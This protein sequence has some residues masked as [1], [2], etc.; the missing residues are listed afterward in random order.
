MS[1]LEDELG[2]VM[3]EH[4]DEA[5]KAAELL[6][7][8]PEAPRRRRGSWYVVAAA[9]VL[10]VGVLA[11]VWAARDRAHGPTGSRPTAPVRTLSCPA[12]YAGAAPWVP[13]KPT[14]IDAKSRL[15]PLKSPASALICAYK[16]LNG[17]DKQR[18]WAL[19]GRRLLAGELDRL[20]AEL[21]WQPRSV[22]DRRHA[23]TLMAG[24]QVNYLI[25]LAYP[26]GGTIWVSATDEPNLCVGGANGEFTA[27]TGFAGRDV[28]K[29]YSTGVWP[30]RQPANCRL[31]GGGRLGQDTTMV[32]AGVTSLTICTNSGRV[33]K[34][35]YESLVSALNK[36]PISPSNGTCISH[37]HGV[38]YQLLFSYPAGPPAVVDVASACSPPIDNLSA[39]A[40][41]TGSVLPIIQQLLNKH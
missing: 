31:P 1:R 13:A 41:S 12:A 6:A 7:V 40:D 9:A 5:P 17:L 26:G 39:Q 30:A 16:G 3:A 2:Q 22:P 11:G 15:V 35:G 21:S 27:D 29:A 37:G 28:T 10:V 14:G 4:D 23:C 25:G 36:L 8:L 24:T 20:T 32:P 18:G 38:T 19:S 34:S 33:I